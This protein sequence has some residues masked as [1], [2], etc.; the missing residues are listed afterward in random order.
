MLKKRENP[1]VN[2]GSMADIAFLLLIF[3]LVTTT[4]EPNTGIKRMLPLNKQEGTIYERNILRIN[5]NGNNELMVDKNV[6]DIKN[7]RATTT[8]FLDNG[9]A[10]MGTDDYCSFCKGKRLTNSSDS[11]NKAVVSVATHRNTDYETFIAVQNELV[12]A[13]NELRDREAKRLYATS[14][15]TLKLAYENSKNNPEVRLQLQHKI[16]RIQELFPMKISEAE[17]KN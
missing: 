17:I 8:A 12:G 16:K 9:G 3:F 2:A 11:P 6:I 1:E 4:L 7:L 5:I 13:Y 14:F 10:E 15:E